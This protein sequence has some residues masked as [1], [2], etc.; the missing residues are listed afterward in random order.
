LYVKVK[1]GKPTI[2]D[3]RNYLSSTVAHGNLTA[4]AMEFHALGIVLLEVQ[5][6]K[7]EVSVAYRHNH[8]VPGIMNIEWDGGMGKEQY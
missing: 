8:F 7:W 3:K 1:Q 6:C 5:E 2:N 4:V